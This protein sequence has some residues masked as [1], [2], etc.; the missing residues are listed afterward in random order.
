MQLSINALGIILSLWVQDEF[1]SN[2]VISQI[3]QAHDK[4]GIFSRKRV[5][6]YFR[7]LWILT[8]AILIIIFLL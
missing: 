1:I 5:I 4:F 7:N 2:Y 6:T 3:E 8:A